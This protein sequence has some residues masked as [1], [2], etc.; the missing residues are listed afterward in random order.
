LIFLLFLLNLNKNNIFAKR[1]IMNGPHF[2]RRTKDGLLVYCCCTKSYQLLFKNINLNF[3]QDEMESFYKYVNEIDEDFWEQEYCN[4]IYS[5]KIPI[6][7][8]QTNL[9][10]LLDR[11]DLYELRALLNFRDREIK[12]IGFRE[13]DYTIL[14]N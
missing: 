2:L 10:I 7:S 4:S 11:I 9:M 3:T 14:L 5:K 8:E 6:P 13:I 1:K 12:I